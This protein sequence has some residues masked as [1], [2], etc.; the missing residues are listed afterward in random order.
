MI[1]NRSIQECLAWAFEY[2]YLC[3]KFKKKEI[4][5]LKLDLEKVFDK[6]EHQM[7][8][9]ILQAKGFGAKW[10]MDRH[11]PQTGACSMLLNGVPGKVFHFRRGVRQG[12]PLSLLLF[13]LAADLLQSIMNKGK[14]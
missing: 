7:N 5:L 1:K 4:V 12:D 9:N 6:I 13:V 2:L 10:T 8:L 14:D 3:Q 11:Y